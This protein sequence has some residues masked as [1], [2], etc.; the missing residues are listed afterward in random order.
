MYCTDEQK[1]AVYEFVIEILHGDWRHKDWLIQSAR[2]YVNSG[3]VLTEKEHLILLLE[4]T[5]ISNKEFKE[6]LND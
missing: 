1:K 2:S 3:K 5:V 6:F 4:A